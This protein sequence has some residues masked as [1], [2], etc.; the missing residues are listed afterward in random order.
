MQ[1]AQ[2]V[3]MTGRTG[4]AAGAIAAAMLL[5]NAA[6]AQDPPVSGMIAIGP[7]TDL[8]LEVKTGEDGAPML[9]ADSY[10]LVLGSYYRFNFVCPDAADDSTGFHLEVTNL[11]ANSH[12]RVITIGE[13]EVYMQGM[14]FRALECD[15][16]G[17]AQFS[18]HPMRPGVYDLYVRDHSDPPKE[19][20]GKITVE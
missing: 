7:P 1:K 16:A 9:S 13:M 10:A 12:L 8:T 11:M 19:A 5:A 18:F 20:F 6:M 3:T 4:I 17:A 14:A 15:G 2:G